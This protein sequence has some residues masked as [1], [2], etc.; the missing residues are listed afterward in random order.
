MS[1]REIENQKPHTTTNGAKDSLIK[2][3]KFLTTKDH[4]VLFK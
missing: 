2:Y 1:L 4:S 3:E